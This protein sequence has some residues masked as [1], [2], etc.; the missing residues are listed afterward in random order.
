MDQAR[1]KAPIH[2]SER[3]LAHGSSSPVPER[4]SGPSH[5]SEPPGKPMSYRF[6]ALVL[7]PAVACTSIHLDPDPQY[8]S[9]QTRDIIPG[10]YLVYSRSADAPAALDPVGHALEPALAQ[11]AP[12]ADF[13]SV[14]RVHT[15]H[16]LDALRA[17]LMDDA[18][19]LELEPERLAHAFATTPDDPY[20]SYQWHM[21]AIGVPAVW[22][23]ATGAGVTVA[24]L[25][26]G[27]SAGADGFRT[28]LRGR[29]FADGDDR[30]DDQDGHGTHVAGTVCQASDN[31]YGTI[32]VAPDAAL[33]PVRVLGAGG[34]GS[35]T[36]VADGIV[37]AVDE[38]AD[39]I[40]LSLGAGGGARALEAAVRYARDSG[41]V[42]VAASGNEGRAAVSWPAAYADA[43]AV[44]AVDFAGDRAPYSNGG[45]ALDLVAPGGHT[46]VDANGDGYVDGVLQETWQ[47]GRASFQF[48]QGTS[49]AAPHV[50]GAAALLVELVGRDPDRIETLLLDTAEDADATGWDPTTGWG[51]LD[52]AAAVRA[53]MDSERSPDDASDDAPEPAPDDAPSGSDRSE[54]VLL[55]EVMA[56]PST[57]GDAIAEYVEIWND[58]SAAL[59]LADVALLDAAGNGGWVASDRVLEP[60]EVAVLGRVSAAEWPWASV[61]LAGHYPPSLSLNNGGDTV[62]LYVHGAWSDGLRWDASAR[63]IAFERIE[64]GWTYADHRFEGTDHGTPGWIP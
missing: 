22:D 28:L 58:T 64:D 56:D 53:A 1:L 40:N 34:S 27:V 9:L 13:A 23:A 4:F 19:V 46:G 42:V 11:P 16:D 37:W 25:D 45:N 62:E 54:Q 35:L 57:Y 12:T 49:M 26:T 51:R 50:A 61:A 47:G 14:W 52:A 31:G 8:P 55:T 29:D 20:R 2:R 6:C 21:D 48:L 60:G 15:D 17:E 43:L 10:Q 18:D 7:T 30:P 38:G 39:V 41:V 44:G 33:L 24:V 3:R 32:G 59:S 63:G 5:C 36:D